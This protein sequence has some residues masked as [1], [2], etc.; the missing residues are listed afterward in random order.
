MIL[1][2]ADRYWV[3]SCW[4]LQACYTGVVYGICGEK[5]VAEMTM[6][7]QW[8]NGGSRNTQDL[9]SEMQMD[10][11]I[12][13]LICESWWVW[14]EHLACLIC[15]DLY[16]LR[17]YICSIWFSLI[18]WVVVVTVSEVAFD[19]IMWVN[20]CSLFTE[21]N[22]GHLVETVIP[23]CSNTLV[24]FNT[25]SDSCSWENLDPKKDELCTASVITWLQIIICLCVMP[26]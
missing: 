22:K 21:G 19:S 1:E 23:V 16:V 4:L 18:Q 26:V 12:I 9:F 11:M 7:T 17:V 13:Q 15:S 3:N 10:W 24:S 5:R 14:L 6:I 8:L 2:S 20:A 25:Y